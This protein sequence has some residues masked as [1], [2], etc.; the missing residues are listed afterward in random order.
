M[1]K[2]F[3]VLKPYCKAVKNKDNLNK[4]MNKLRNIKFQST[5]NLIIK[6]FAKTNYKAL[7]FH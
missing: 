3:S 5:F 1:Y 6:L 7:F 2:P 4:R